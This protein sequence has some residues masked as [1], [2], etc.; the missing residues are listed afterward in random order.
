[1]RPE[2]GHVGDPGDVWKL[3]VE[4]SLKHLW[5]DGMVVF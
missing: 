2:I 3:D 5:S 1:M 4:F